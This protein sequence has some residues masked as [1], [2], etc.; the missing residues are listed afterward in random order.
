MNLP[1]SLARSAAWKFWRSCK[2]EYVGF[3]VLNLHSVLNPQLIV[4]MQ[5]AQVS[6][7]QVSGII[8]LNSSSSVV[9]HHCSRARSNCYSDRFCD[10]FVTIPRCYNDVYV[11][12]FF[13]RTARLWNCVLIECFP[14][15]YDLKILK[16]RI[17]R[18]F[19]RRFLLNRFCV[20]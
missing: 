6:G 11:N 2:S 3:L 4:E 8:H 14:L 10:F 18:K 19:I 17:N 16:S 9:P 15:I 12:S 1:Y 20:C 7:S 13:P 5:P